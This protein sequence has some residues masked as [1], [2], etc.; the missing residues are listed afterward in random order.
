M[1]G[2][3]IGDI[4]SIQNQETTNKNDKTAMKTSH[5]YILLSALAL[6]GCAEKSNENNNVETNLTEYYA[7]TPQD[8]IGNEPYKQLLR[9][10]SARVEYI[11]LKWPMGFPP[12]ATIEKVEGADSSLIVMEYNDND[13]QMFDTIEAKWFELMRLCSQKQ[14][15]DALSLYIKEETD[16]GVALVNSTNKFDLD[17]HVIGGL[18]LDLLTKEEAMELLAR[19]LE[20]DKSFT[21]SV[22]ILSTTNDGSGFIPPHYSTLIGTLGAIYTNLGN[23]T[24]AE[25]LI[26][27]FRNAV[28]LLSDNVWDN[29]QEIVSYKLAIYHNS[30]DYA[31]LKETLEEYL[32][33]V[34]DYSAKSGENHDTLIEHLEMS[35]EDLE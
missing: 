25:E 12:S 10:D 1:L 4:L 16:I 19:F 21:E 31:K 15:E 5:F 26:E 2:A 23:E 34:I 6:L 32:A 18:L 9:I 3:I 7:Y 20:Y 33:F 30:N 11:Q 13:K 28:Y 22:I 35:I 8:T 14:Y 27:P 29:E 17:Y 24:K